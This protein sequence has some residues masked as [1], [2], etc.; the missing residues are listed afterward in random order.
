MKNTILI[1]MTS[2]GELGNT[3][4]ATGFHY[5]EMTTPY[6]LFKDAGF[7]VLLAS[8]AGGQPPFDPSSLNSSPSD[9]PESV[10]RFL[11]DDLA[12][13]A[14]KH[15]RS[16]N[17]VD[18]DT[19][20]SFD[21]IYLPGGHGTLWDF[22]NNPYLEPIVS[23]LFQLGKPVAAVCHGVAGFIGATDAD[24][25]P[26]VKGKRVNSFTNAEECSIELDTTV[27]YL[28]ESELRELG[29]KFESSDN[30]RAHV[31][32]D[33]N[34]I[35]GQNPASAEGVAKAVVKYLAA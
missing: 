15:S 12:V 21:A 16:L 3:G 4:K 17:E 19:L 24:G 13:N 11:K 32:I 2:H 29:C 20:T 28:L 18:D 8:I 22:R 1:V 25:S 7:D 35:S 10:Q 5:E 27:P 6:Y 26:M 14:L 23:T 30:F 31:A 9:N 34:L 33:G